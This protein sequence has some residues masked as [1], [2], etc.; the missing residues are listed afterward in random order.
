MEENVEEGQIKGSIDI[1]SIDK[2]NLLSEQMKKCICKIDGDK[3]GTGF[4]CKINYG[5]KLIPVL[6]TNYH[7]VNSDYFERENN[8]IVSTNEKRF[9]INISNNN[10]LYSSTNKEYDLMIIRLNESQD[11]INNYLEIDKHIFSNKSEKTYENESIYILHYPSGRKPSISFGYGFKQKNNY[12]M[13]HRCNTENCSSG[14]PI[15]SL[16]SNQIIG[17]HRGCIR[18]KDGTT[19]NYGTFLKFPLNELNQNKI[20][21]INSI[22]ENNNDNAKIMRK[23]I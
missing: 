9:V 4:F 21:K 3:K 2:I 12:N 7:V 6:M 19:T 14:G 10:I 11:E 1:I 5:N 20:N 15:L 17:I 8:L 23:Q 22:I 13:Y 16:S 18:K